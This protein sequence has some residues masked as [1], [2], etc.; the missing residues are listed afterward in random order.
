[1]AETGL[2]IND[3]LEEI[4]KAVLKAITYR[5]YPVERLDAIMSAID[6]IIETPAY[7]RQCEQHL[8]SAS[9]NYILFFLSNIIYNL[10]KRGELVLTPEVLK[11]LGSVWKNFLK[12]S[13]SYQEL[14]PAIDDQRIRLKRYYPSGGVFVNQIENVNQ[15]RE[16][17]VE[18]LDSKEKTLN[19]LEKFYQQSSELLTWMRPTYFFLVDFF[20]ECKLSTG[21]DIAG[22][23]EIEAKGLAKFG[24]NNY[25][26]S[27]ITVVV[28]QALGVLEASYLILK[29]KR[30]SRRIV[31]FDGKQ[32]FLTPSE[33]YNMYLEKFNTMK[34]EITNLNK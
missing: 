27:E 34:K 16:E 23:A 10:K 12:R 18:T 29:K 9:S 4:G 7:L 11:W 28:C 13:K 1:M 6:V 31:S 24:E 21:K 25:N 2:N 20:Y 14:F 33:I 19:T 8:K 17:F 5:R 32:K 3:S 22:S 15:V 26:Y 30:S